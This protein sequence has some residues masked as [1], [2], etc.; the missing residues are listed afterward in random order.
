MWRC[1]IYLKSPGDKLYLT[2]QTLTFMTSTAHWSF[3]HQ[4]NKV[5]GF[6]HWSS[7][8]ST[9]VLRL[10]GFVNQHQKCVFLLNQHWLDSHNKY[11]PCKS[12]ITQHWA[13]WYITSLPWTHTHCRLLSWFKPTS[14]VLQLEP[15]TTNTEAVD[16][17]L[18]L[19]PDWDVVSRGRLFVGWF[20]ED[21]TKT[22]ETQSLEGGWG[23][24]VSPD[25][26]A[27]PG[28]I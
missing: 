3:P 25:H 4:F 19:Q 18:K 26:W 22:T 16:P 23:T 27:E 8:R 5:N 10:W 20:K 21:Y 13:E 1:F 28:T 12:L 7:I 11:C 24:G 9:W 15:E 6:I 17:L 2:N 14:S